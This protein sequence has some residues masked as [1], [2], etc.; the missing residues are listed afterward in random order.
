MNARVAAAVDAPVLMV[1]DA[2]SELTLEVRLLAVLEHAMALLHYSVA[3]NTSC[4]MISMRLCCQCLCLCIRHC[5]LCHNGIK[6]CWHVIS[7]QW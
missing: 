6:A 4:R 5:K 1:L 3:E 7:S 2:P